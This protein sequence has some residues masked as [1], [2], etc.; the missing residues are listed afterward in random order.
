[1]TTTES[2]AKAETRRSWARAAQL[3]PAFRRVERRAAR[4]AEEARDAAVDRSR[5]VR[6]AAR[7]ATNTLIDT[8]DAAALKVRHAPLR[9]VAA[10]AGVMFMLGA[11]TGWM[12]TRRD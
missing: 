7:R 1:M 2:P 10:T 4:M 8:R 3:A 9:S 6:R 12:F 5:V 11:V